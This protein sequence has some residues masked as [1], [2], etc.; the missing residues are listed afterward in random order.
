[1]KPGLLIRALSELTGSG[2][3]VPAGLPARDDAA[4]LRPGVRVLL[5]DDNVVNQKVATHML[6][7]FG[8]LVHCVGNGRE[9]LQA[10][11]YRDFDL[12]LMDCQMPEMDGYEATRELRKSDGVY[13]NRA[14]PIIALTANALASDRDLCLAAGMNDFLSKPIDRARLEESL[15]RAVQSR[16]DQGVSTADRMMM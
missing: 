16:E 15:L 2:N 5:A 3:A 10:L 13:K 7:K 9:A 12:V 11:R 4:A 14:I 1:M 8:A 6:R